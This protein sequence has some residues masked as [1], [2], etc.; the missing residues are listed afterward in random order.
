MKNKLGFIAELMVILGIF[1]SLTGG[2]TQSV[3]AETCTWLGNNSIW[4]DTSN[5]SCGHVPTT[6]DDVVI[7]VTVSY[8]HLTL[9]T[10][11]IV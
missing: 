2:L 6:A 9:P 10:K 1:L 8:T 4:G 7:P 5:W 11:R 3:H